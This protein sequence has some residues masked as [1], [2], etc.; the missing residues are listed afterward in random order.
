LH[1]EPR[2]EQ[3]G[4]KR[5]VADRDGARRGVPDHLADTEIF[6]A[7][8]G[9]GLCHFFDRPCQSGAATP[10]RF[11]PHA[12]RPEKP[13]RSRDRVSETLAKSHRISF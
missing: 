13:S 8:A 2:A 3:A 5:D 4:V 7:I 10:G 1:R 11:I 9:A 12:R 6:K